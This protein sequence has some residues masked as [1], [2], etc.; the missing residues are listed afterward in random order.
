MRDYDGYWGIWACERRI[1]S[2][3]H[4]AAEAALLVNVPI[5]DFV[6]HRA[7]VPHAPL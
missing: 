2:R 1:A 6:I 4:L 5:S 7:R 3:R